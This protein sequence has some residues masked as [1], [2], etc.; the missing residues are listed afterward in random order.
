MRIGSWAT[1]FQTEEGLCI[2]SKESSFFVYLLH[3]ESGKRI[4]KGEKV[5]TENPKE[6]WM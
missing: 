3:E 2:Q 5:I 1:K 6:C 4:G